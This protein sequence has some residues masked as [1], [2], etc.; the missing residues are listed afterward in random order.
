MRSIIIISCLLFAINSFGQ[1]RI[2]VDLNSHMMNLNCT[3]HYQQVIKGP[4]LYSAGFFFGGNGFGSNYNTNAAVE[5]GLDIGAA[6]PGIPS[7]YIDTSGT[8]NLKSYSTKGSGFGV[9][10]G[11]G[12][13]QEFGRSHGVRFN[14]NNRFGWMK[15]GMIVYYHM[16]GEERSKSTRPDIYHPV[17]AVTLELY[18]TFR[19]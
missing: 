11:L 13:F 18:H 17:G 2:G 7:T 1:K 16:D 12:I 15:S 5:N 6:Y 4:F 14:I 8:Y 10:V 9:H 19:I 3:M